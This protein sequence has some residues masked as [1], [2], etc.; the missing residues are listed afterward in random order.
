MFSVVEN[1]WTALF[2]VWSFSLMF[3]Y[4]FFLFNAIKMSTFQF[5]LSYV[6]SIR[7][8]R[9]V[10]IS[11]VVA[12]RSTNQS[13]GRRNCIHLNF[14]CVRSTFIRYYE[15]QYFFFFVSVEHNTLQF[16]LHSFGVRTL[17]KDSSSFHFPSHR[18]IPWNWYKRI[19]QTRKIAGSIFFCA[20]INGNQKWIVIV[21]FIVMKN[22]TSK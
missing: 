4:F 13:G 1:V 15:R 10:I 12:T 7:A 14:C 9:S 18:L 6:C 17:G 3:R 5:W 16:G 2:H 20:L 22:P 19:I 8:Q 11:N 21:S